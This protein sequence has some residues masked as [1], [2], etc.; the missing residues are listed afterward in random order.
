MPVCVWPCTSK[1]DDFIRTSQG[2]KARTAPQV[3]RPGTTRRHYRML[4]SHAYGPSV[5]YLHVLL[6]RGWGD[7]IR[8]PYRTRKVQV[9]APCGFRTGM[10]TSVRSV[11]RELYRSRADAMR[12]WEYTFNRWCRTLQGPV[13][14]ASARSGY[15]YQAKHDYVTFDPLGPGKL[16]T[17]LLWHEIAGSHVWK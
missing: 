7:T 14:P 5:G 13:R 12:A 6:S 2:S 10:G 17:G 11:L 1:K 4:W 8:V 9:R 3:L 16:L 15:I